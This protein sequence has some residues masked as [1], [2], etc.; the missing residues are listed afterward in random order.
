MAKTGTA[1]DATSAD[2]G[3][4]DTGSASVGKKV[5]AKAGVPR[6]SAMITALDFTNAVDESAFTTPTRKTKWHDELGK[7]YDATAAGLVGRSTDGALKF[8]KIGAY[9]N[10]NGA[11]TQARA[12]EKVEATNAAYEF[13]YKVNADGSELYARVKEVTNVA[14]ENVPAA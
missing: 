12:F 9:R 5:G 4:A 3:S 14:P 7:V 2:T 8:T 13:R 1:P 6:P 10:P 11:R